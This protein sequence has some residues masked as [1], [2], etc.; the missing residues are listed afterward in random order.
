M[1]RLFFFVFS[2]TTTIYNTVVPSIHEKAKIIAS[3]SP[4]LLLPG[5][6][7]LI[8]HSCAAKSDAKDI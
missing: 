7:A 4:N 6:L 1:C 5:F 8:S 2:Y 3:G